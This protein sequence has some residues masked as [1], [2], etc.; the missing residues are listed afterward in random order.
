MVSQNI[1]IAVETGD[2]RPFHA[3]RIFLNKSF[4][5]ILSSKPYE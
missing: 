1:I 2:G 3:P 4:W 5:D